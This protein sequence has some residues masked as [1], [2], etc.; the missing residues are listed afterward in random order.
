MESR[1]QFPK[2][3]WSDFINRHRVWL[4]GHPGFQTHVYTVESNLLFK[5][6]KEGELRFEASLELVGTGEE[7]LDFGE[8]IFLK[9]KG[10]FAKPVGGG[11]IHLSPPRNRGLKVPYSLFPSDT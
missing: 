9:G 3:E 8:W 5:M 4:N 2:K 6:G 11:K 10:F 1:K 7:I